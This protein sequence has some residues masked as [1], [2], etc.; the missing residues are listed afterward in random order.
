MYE[1]KN[2]IL[3]QDGKPIIA[4]GQSYYPSFHE[5]KYPAPPAGDR[6]GLMKEDIKLM[7]EAG[8]QFLRVA[9]IGNVTLDENDQVK[10]DTPFVD[11]MLGYKKL[12][13]AGAITKEEFE[14]KKKQLLGL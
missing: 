4:M 3:Y 2:G 13:D 9:A 12:L 6:I 10:V 14:K 11:E 1:L 7:R 8:F 5:A